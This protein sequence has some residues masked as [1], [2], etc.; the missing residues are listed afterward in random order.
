MFLA[1]LSCMMLYYRFFH[2]MGPLNPFQNKKSSDLEPGA[3]ANTQVTTSSPSSTSTSPDYSTKKRPVMHK[4][5]MKRTFKSLYPVD[6]NNMSV[7]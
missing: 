6:N 1:G 5:S 2:P 4:V 3:T 7:R